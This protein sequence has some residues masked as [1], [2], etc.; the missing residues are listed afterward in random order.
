MATRTTYSAARQG[1]AQLCKRVS[2]NREAVIIGRRG[3]ADVALIAADELASLE[4]TAHLLRSPANARR[5]LRA[6]ERALRGGGRRRTVAQVRD[7]LGL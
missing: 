1:L 7:K 6:L 2:E 5:L 4:A 3:H